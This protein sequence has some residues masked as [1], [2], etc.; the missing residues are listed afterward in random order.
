MGNMWR[1]IAAKVI[2]LIKWAETLAGKT[3]PEKKALVVKGLC[4][5]V[6]IPFMP[7]WAE[8][9]IEPPLYGFIA[10]FLVGVWN[11]VTGHALEKIPEGP[12]VTEEMA[13][14]VKQELKAAATGTKADIEDKLR[15]LS[16]K[17]GVREQA[18][19]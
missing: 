14:M 19:E 15:A 8:G 13:E 1:N 4:G 11:R 3:G 6:D 5:A 7:E 16:E 10:D 17:Y 18:R 9:L 12:E 2:E